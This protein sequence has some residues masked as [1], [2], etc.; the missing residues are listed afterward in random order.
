LATAKLFAEEGDYVFITG[1]RK[2]QLDCAVREIG[3]S[4]TGVQ[5]DAGNLAD[6]DRQAAKSPMPSHLHHARQWMDLRALYPA[7]SRIITCALPESAFHIRPLA[8][9]ASPRMAAACGRSGDRRLTSG[10]L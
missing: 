3:K 1:R 4:V 8:L 6:L 7:F 9:H 10:R 2:E 5:G